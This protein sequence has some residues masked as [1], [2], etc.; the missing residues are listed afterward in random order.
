V[1]ITG[2]GIAAVATYPITENFA[3]MGKLGV[4]RSDEDGSITAAGVSGGG[5]DDETG[6]IYGI[7]IKYSFNE[8]V[9]LRGEIERFT[10]M[11]NSA[12]NT[13]D[14]NV[15]LYTVGLAYKF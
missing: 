9:S 4:F 2:Y 11:G 12:G 15:N 13:E 14:S 7:G 3:V 8:N 6:P 1:K 5:S 10:G